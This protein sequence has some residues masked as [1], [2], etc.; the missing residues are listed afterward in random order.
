MAVLSNNGRLIS[1]LPIVSP[2]GREVDSGAKALAD[3]DEFIIQ[4]SGISTRGTYST[5]KTS[6]VEVGLN[7]C[8]TTVN[9][10]NIDDNNFSGSFKSD[11]YNLV[12]L[13]SRDVRLGYNGGDAIAM[14]GIGTEGPDYGWHVDIFT[15]QFTISA[16]GSPDVTP[17]IDIFSDGT[18][19]I[20]SAEDITINNSGSFI[21]NR[22]IEGIAGFTGSLSGSVSASIAYIKDLTVD[23]LSLPGTITADIVGNLNG[24][25]L[26]TDGTKVLE[27][28]TD[29]T[30]ATFTG[31]VTGDVTG[32]VTGDVTSVGTSTFVT[33]T[34][35]N[36]TLT[37]A[38]N[39]DIYSSDGTIVLENGTTGVGGEVAD[40]HFHGTSSWADFAVTAAYALDGP[41]GGGSGNVP[42]GGTI[43]QVLRKASN[44]SYD[45]EWVTPISS[46][47]EG[48]ISNTLAMWSSI[49]NLTASHLSYGAT[50]FTFNKP[51]NSADIT[52]S[53]Q[54][55]TGGK[56]IPNGDVVKIDSG[57]SNLWDT[58][59]GDYYPSI[60]LEISTSMTGTNYVTMSLYNAQTC[61][62]LIQG[63]SGGEDIQWT[64]ISNDNEG[65][66]NILW[67]GG[68]AA[69]P[70]AAASGIQTWRFMNIN[71]TIFGYKTGETYS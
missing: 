48:G 22:P 42:A 1:S 15:N 13:N 26:A 8:D 52:G 51:I 20:V 70:T 66:K 35:T 60:K 54:V 33:I 46:S 57:I 40:A 3:N 65:F 37:G 14:Y 50:G 55:S 58:L 39:G 9:F 45:M 68:T 69:S 12:K 2:S 19:S 4:S 7:P 16:L 61:D 67:N 36:A 28:G 29:G 24:D 56:I 27:N 63:N 64:S 59:Y 23:N 6:L 34:A 53:L 43:Y 44:T 21:S 31:D 71:H 41:G 11:Q 38:L 32:N 47:G 25:V 10:T 18:I 17:S 49:Y 62:V 30:D 5:L